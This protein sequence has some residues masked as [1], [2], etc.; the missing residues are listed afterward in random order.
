MLFVAW[1]VFFVVVIVVVVDDGGSSCGCSC[2]GVFRC[3]SI[4]FSVACVLQAHIHQ[5]IYSIGR[6][7]VLQISFAERKPYV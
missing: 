2:D 3:D 6:G 7:F 1:L 5:R 4:V